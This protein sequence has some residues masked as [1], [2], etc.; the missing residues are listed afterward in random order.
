MASDPSPNSVKTSTNPLKAALITHL[1]EER[2][3]AL[4]GTV[5]NMNPLDESENFKKLCE[6]CRR[7]DVKAVQS[8]VSFEGVNVNAVDRFD[9]PPLTLASLCG[10]Y[11]VVQFLLEN[12]AVCER[13]T[14]QGERCLYN[15]LNNRI[16]QLLLRYD[17]SKSSDPLQPW[18]ASISSL[19]APGPLDSTDVTVIATSGDS[20]YVKEFRL[21]KFLLSAR[22][23]YFRRKLSDFHSQSK[24]KII[25][26][27]R[28]SNSIDSRAFEMAVKFLYLGEVTE[29]WSDEILANVGKISRQIELPE[30]F[31]LALVA[32]EGTERRQ[33]REAAVQKAQNDL[34]KW[35]Q[36]NI[37]RRKI[38]V[39][40]GQEFKDLPLQQHHESFPDIFLKADIDLEEE[41]KT[42]P[43]GGTR[44]VNHVLYPAHRAMLR[45]E[46]FTIM[47]TSQF[48]EAQRPNTDSEPLPIIDTDTSPAILELILNFFYSEKMNIPL[49]H[50]LDLL[51]AAD[52]LFI[53]RLKTIC[54]QVISTAGNSDD[55]PYS[56]YDVIRAGWSCRVRR[57]EE[58]GAK[59][60]AERLENY[61]LD[62]EFSELVEES[63][64]K[65]KERQETDTIELVDDIRYYL[66]HRFRLRM[67]DFNGQMFVEDSESGV[68]PVVENDEEE[69]QKTLEPDDSI[70]YERL[71][72]S[73]DTLLENL[74]LDA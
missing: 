45:S 31:D 17:Y 70:Q 53:E 32:G 13:D 22:S 10:H 50:A 34:D 71:Y 56:I 73:I 74:K 39:R 33:K 68:N 8:L 51:Y 11:E 20:S 29:I 35:F 67:D 4:H 25:K 69:S 43:I 64:R 12:G 72:E 48:R 36:E 9:Y 23:S 7:G 21:H 61:I 27:V 59:Y 63:A 46:Y 38:E 40:E 41:E 44:R 54:A 15:A 55:L 2:N 26:T 57:L 24:G 1:F 30:L 5:R 58:F 14:F 65:I 37:L 66:D 52:Q 3:G 16:R 28:L 49:E 47:F 42:I 18:A 62:K 60:I 19:L 6:A